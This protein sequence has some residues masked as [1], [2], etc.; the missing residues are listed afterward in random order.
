MNRFQ[1]SVSHGGY[2]STRPEN[3]SST[4]QRCKVKPRE[5]SSEPLRTSDTSES[6]S[7]ERPSLAYLQ[8][9]E[10]R[11]SAAKDYHP[12]LLGRETQEEQ[13]MDDEDRHDRTTRNAISSWMGDDHQ[14]LSACLLDESV[15]GESLSSSP[16]H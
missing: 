15:F 14:D 1:V 3:E 4:Q 10:V 7:P 13:D 11:D 2:D 16:A 9:E 8:D 12:H 5:K 6:T